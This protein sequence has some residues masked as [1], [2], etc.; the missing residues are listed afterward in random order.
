MTKVKL[1]NFSM[2][3]EHCQ[4]LEP[5]FIFQHGWAFSDRC[6]QG[7]LKD[8]KS[9]LLV[10]RGYW[11]GAHQPVDDAGYPPGSIIICHSLG[12]HL[13]SPEL[14]SQSRLL[15]VVSGFAHFH[16]RNPENGRFSRKHIQKMLLRIVADPGGLLQDFYRDC[17]CLP[18][19]VDERTLDLA[20]LTQDLILL[21]TNHIDHLSFASLPPVLQIHGS[22]DRI[23]RPER[24]EELADILGTS[25][26]TIIDGAGHG[27]P[28][29]H[30][31]VC[32]DVIR[33]FS[34]T[35]C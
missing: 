24:A 33:N 29:T 1:M 4:N 26:L 31:Q 19:L 12:L 5:N 15:V 23:V 2:R 27:L 6:W 10:N 28:F 11:G 25:Q 7:W 14:L 17:G 3:S 22:K 35:F 21:D 13:L 20:L 32:M 34:E 18:W 16:G 9:F 8:L 30:P